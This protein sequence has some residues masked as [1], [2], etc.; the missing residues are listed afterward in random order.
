M[1][2][3]TWIPSAREP[4]LPE[5]DSFI[6]D[7]FGF[8]QLLSYIVQNLLLSVD[9]CTSLASVKKPSSFLSG[10]QRQLSIRGNS[11]SFLMRSP[12]R[13]LS[14]DPQSLCLLFGMLLLV[15]APLQVW[16]SDLNRRVLRGGLVRGTGT[17]W[18]VE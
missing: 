10:I 15:S 11:P 7:M 13:M 3:T 8:Q 16:G 6:L 17:H 18:R 4:L 5:A 12:Q 1:V 9:A 2:H 14:D